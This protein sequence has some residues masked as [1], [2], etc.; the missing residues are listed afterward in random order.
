MVWESPKTLDHSFG[1]YA[2]AFAG[3]LRE[4]HPGSATVLPVPV[5]ERV[6]VC[7]GSTGQWYG[8]LSQ[9][10]YVCNMLDA[11]SCQLCCC[12]A[13]SGRR[14]LQADDLGTVALSCQLCTRCMPAL[15][16]HATKVMS[17]DNALLLSTRVPCSSAR[18][19]LSLNLSCLVG[20]EQKR[21]F[22]AELATIFAL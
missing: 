6:I 1:C 11:F 3:P 10:L 8:L 22:T 21:P 2:A 15:P 4:Y 19:K 13:R 12:H 5:T 9:C 16:Q 14:Q 17:R 7:L 18:F 20:S